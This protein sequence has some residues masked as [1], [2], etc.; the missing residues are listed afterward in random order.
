MPWSRARGLVNAACRRLADAGT[1][2]HNRFTENP[3]PLWCHHRVLALIKRRSL[4]A[5]RSAVEPVDQTTYAR[6]LPM[7][8][9]VGSGARGVDGLLGVIDQLAGCAVPASMWE[10]LVL[11]CRVVDYAPA[12]LDE[13]LASGEAVWTGDG[14]IGD[15]DGWVRLWPA[16]LVAPPTR[17]LPESAAALALWERLS[18]GGGWFF[19]DLITDELGRADWERGLWE[20]VWGGRVRSD[21]FA[22]IR[23]LAGQGSLKTRRAPRTRSRFQGQL[24]TGNI[25]LPLQ[26]AMGQGSC[27]GNSDEQPS[28]IIAE[29]HELVPDQIVGIAPARGCLGL[30]DGDHVYLDL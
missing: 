23:A 30:R 5:L 7:W 3:E 2:V 29:D 19:D 21:T 4:A 25:A 13:V 17:P 8:Q 15:S 9:G 22:P 1:L 28:Q 14:A 6:F 26:C 10:S 11:P 16:E 27:S 24:R 20:L 12:F 18:G